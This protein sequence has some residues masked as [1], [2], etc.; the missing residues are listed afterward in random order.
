MTIKAKR[1]ELLA[2]VKA[3][4][5][6]A[7][8]ATAA[9]A[10]SIKAAAAPM[11]FVKQPDGSSIPSPAMQKRI[12]EMR[13]MWLMGFVASQLQADSIAAGKPMSE[14]AALELAEAVIAGAPHD[15]K[16]SI[17]NRRRRTK[18]EDA[19]MVNSRQYWRRATVLAGIASV[20]PNAGN[21]NAKGNTKAGQGKAKADKAAKPEAA[22]PAKPVDSA[23]MWEHTT[24]QA[25]SLFA[26]CCKANAKLCPNALSTIVTDFRNAIRAARPAE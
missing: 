4:A 10:A 21:T 12:D 2:N 19:I 15:S 20:H 13:P 14:A 18:R 24:L 26:Y 17:G 8:T 1:A 22:K 7:G 25:D 3:D 6:R 5:Y 9:S 23:A 11:Q 16:G